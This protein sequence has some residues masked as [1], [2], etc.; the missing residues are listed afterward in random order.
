MNNLTTS[1]SEAKHEDPIRILFVDD[2]TAILSSLKRLFR[3]TEYQ[4]FTAESGKAGL[5]VLE[6][7]E[8]DVIVSDMRMPE[9]SGVEFLTF[10]AQKWPNRARIV[11]TGH[12]DLNQA[13]KAINQGH[14][15][16][17]LN[18]PWDDWDIQLTVKQ[19]VSQAKLLRENLELGTITE[20]QYVEL[21]L[22]NESLE[23]KVNDRTAKLKAT[24]ERLDEAYAS[25][26]TGYQQT[27]E[28][29]SSLADMKQNNMGNHGRRVAELSREIAQSLGLNKEEIG[30]IY[31]AGLLHD[32][33][34]L[35]LPDEL[36][37]R[38]LS[39]LSDK[40]RKVRERHPALA[41]A[42]LFRLDP[43]L[44]A[45]RII[46]HHHEQI[47]GNGYPDQISGDAIP[48][49]SRIL[50][51]S[52]AYDGLRTGTGTG[53][54]HSRVEALKHIR[55]NCGTLYDERIFSVLEKIK[56]NRAEQ[57]AVTSSV[58]M[59]N[60]D[61]LNPGMEIA[62]DLVNDQGLL[63]LTAGKVL[64]ATIIERLKQ[65]EV[66]FDTEYTLYVKN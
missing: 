20:R 61:S 30:E 21:K 1:K 42:A 4:V 31:D 29:F 37:D 11:L 46:R 62:R 14:I 27:V 58:V 23:Q 60:T 9:M 19:A 39:R 24:A 13:I 47:D 3:S 10:C 52:D 45:A 44:N 40:E 53:A 28:V 65:F 38:P 8:I 49:G 64:N 34:R 48:L 5:E 57:T 63:L 26:K 50:A 32:I 35:V 22:L 15:Y 16:R 43:L 66:D 54:T 6:K 7:N 59:L 12:E 18:K 17:Y 55:K 25:L 36:Y 41:E 33:G 2:E 56:E 51:V